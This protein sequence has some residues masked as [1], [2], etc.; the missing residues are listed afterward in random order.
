MSVPE[1]GS[2]EDLHGGFP[3]PPIPKAA[4]VT[5]GGRRIG[6]ALALALADWGYAVAIHHH[7]SRAE[8]DAVVAEIAD[9]GG[10]AAA[11][12]ADLAD[13]AAVRRLL[14]DAAAALG[15]IGVLVNN[16]SIFENDTVAT[17][18]RDSWTRISPSTC[19]RRL[20]WPRTSRRSSRR[21][22][23]ASWSIC[24]TSGCGT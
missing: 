22:P 6:R 16:A 4:L 24:S 21:R 12:A 17:A 2:F 14:P 9:G 10:K 3:P 19:G 8:A 13:E 23:A 1:P 18:T 11:F 7:A 15:S 20:C 5:G